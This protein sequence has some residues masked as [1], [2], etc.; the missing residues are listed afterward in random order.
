MF[1][2]GVGLW[3]WGT[4]KWFFRFPKTKAKCNPVGNSAANTQKFIELLDDVP[5]SDAVTIKT[6]LQGRDG[7][8]VFRRLVDNILSD[9]HIIPVVWADCK[10]IG[11]I[12]T[13]HYNQIK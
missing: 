9:P 4:R 8:T 13:I 3:S 12:K 7:A 6:Y 1:I 5:T 10:L 11:K 2:T